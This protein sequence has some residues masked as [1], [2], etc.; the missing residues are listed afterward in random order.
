LIVA[1]RLILRDDMRER[2][3]DSI[4]TAFHEGD[5][6]VIIVILPENERLLFSERF[7][8]PDHPEVKFLEPTPR[9]FS[10]NNPYGS[11]PECTGFGAT[12]EYDPALLV[13]NPARSL[14]EGAVDP[15]E[16]PRYKR[17]RTKLLA[18]AREKGVSVDEPWADLPKAFRDEVVRGRRRGFQGVIPFLRSREPKRYKQYIRVF[19][20]QYQSAHECATCRGSRLRGEAL[21]IRVGGMDIGAASRLPIG[22]LRGW[23]D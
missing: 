22:R 17:Y 19:L 5:G 13:P 10:F 14:K 20:R 3:A 21:Q 23:L 8:C 6:E 15:W 7:H 11:C 9:L 12:L 1:D 18:F 4:G 16:K 2:L